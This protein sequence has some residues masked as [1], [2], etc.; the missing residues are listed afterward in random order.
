MTPPPPSQSP[1]T[2][3]PSTMAKKGKPAA[4]E[5]DSAAILQRKASMRSD[6]AEGRE[7]AQPLTSPPVIQ[8]KDD[9]PRT[10]ARTPSQL[11]EMSRMLKKLASSAF[12]KSK[13]AAE[14]DNATESAVRPMVVMPTIADEEME[15]TP[16]WTSIAT[17]LAY[18]L[19]MLVGHFRDFFGKIFYPSRY[20]NL[21]EQDVL[22]MHSIIVYVGVCSTGQRL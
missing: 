4:E 17:Y 21:R 13:S 3:P 15:V 6:E 7:T 11:E 10:H 1:I 22:H 18:L 8:E 2:S 14:E 20:K 19:L 12:Q 16:Y 5:N 9:G